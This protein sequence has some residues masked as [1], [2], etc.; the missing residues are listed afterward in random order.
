MKCSLSKMPSCLPKKRQNDIK[1]TIIAPTVL[2]TG[3]QQLSS[4][5]VDPATVLQCESIKKFPKKVKESWITQKMGQSE[6]SP[7]KYLKV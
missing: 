5:D 4:N 2:L 7:E 3:A 6:C 1:K